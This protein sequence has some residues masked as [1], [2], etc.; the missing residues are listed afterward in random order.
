MSKIGYGFFELKVIA[1]RTT[2]IGDCL[3]HHNETET[4]KNARYHDGSKDQTRIF[5]LLYL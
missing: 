5:H 3:H 2:E 4:D 1:P